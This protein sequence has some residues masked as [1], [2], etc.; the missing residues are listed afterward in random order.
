MPEDRSSES[1]AA[2]EALTPSV[3]IKQ[4]P[5]LRK[6]RQQIRDRA[7]LL[8][9]DLEKSLPLERGKIEAHAR[10]LI[11]ELGQPKEYVGWAMVVLSTAFWR[12]QV[13]KIPYHR[14]LFLLPHCLR[15]ADICP[16]RY[17]ELG[18]LC[19]DCGTCRLADLRR[20][21]IDLGYRVLIAE[22]SPIVM[23][24]ILNDDVDAILGVACLDVLEKSLEKILM[25]GVPCMAVPLH[26][27]SCRNTST[28]EDWVREMILTPYQP[29]DVR[30]QTYVHLLRCS[31]GMFRPEELVRLL[32]T[33]RHQPPVGIDLNKIDAIESTEAIALDFLTA[34]GKRARSFVTLAVH[35]AMTG[36]HATGSYG[37]RHVSNIPD[38]IK[39]V[40]LSMEIFHKASLVHDDIEDD[41]TFRYGRQTLHRKHGLSVAINTGDFLIGLGYQLVA[42][43]RSELG[44]DIV[45]DIQSELAN[46]H[47]KLC[48]GQGAEL[49][50]RDV[51]N[52]ALAPLDAL[53]IYALKTAPAFEVALYAGIRMACSADSY[54][55][56]IAR[57][58]KHLG[59]A[60][61]ILN[62]LG[63]WQFDDANKRSRCTDVLRRRPTV[64]LALALEDSHDKDRVI[65]ESILTN[66]TDETDIV[67]A[68]RGVYER[69]SAFEKATELIAKQHLFA[70][71][72]A[73]SVRPKSLGRLFQYLANSILKR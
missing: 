14:R 47:T 27:S 51:A 30:T 69:S 61:Q 35:D 68:T 40:A 4:V 17:T 25:A 8:A 59:V 63:D 29:A 46:A 13:A 43:Q 18:L 66:S 37:G 28:D 70:L 62:D 42:D 38:S 12:N 50:W 57:F 5:P 54:R 45:A 16:A 56:P 22:G 6:V 58:A 15:D 21:A 1:A 67:E 32:S 33:V 44:A 39:R 2:P 72:V 49:I 7:A 71:E 52:K 55:E 48:R 19:E 34:G 73:E 20:E 11:I 65:L 36:G 41:D 9:D 53:K 60:F 3:D 23:Q 24:L 31:T 64:L 26:A 10:Q